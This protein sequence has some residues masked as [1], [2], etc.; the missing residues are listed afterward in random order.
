MQVIE[1]LNLKMRNLEIQSRWK[2]ALGKIKQQ[3]ARMTHDELVFSE[4]KQEELIGRIE[5]LPVKLGK[6]TR[7]WRINVASVE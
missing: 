4:G 1:K 2:I 6:T 7:W 5:N 3:Y